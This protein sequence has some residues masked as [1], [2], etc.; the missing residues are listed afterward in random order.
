MAD[1]GKRVVAQLQTCGA[2]INH[3]GFYKLKMER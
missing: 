2:F 3:Y 1:A